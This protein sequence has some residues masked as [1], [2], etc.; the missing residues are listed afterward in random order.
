M[1]SRLGSAK[2]LL[3][4]ALKESSRSNQSAASLKAALFAVSRNGLSGVF[5]LNGESR[6]ESQKCHTIAAEFDEQYFAQPEGSEQSLSNF[7]KARSVSALAFALAGEHDEAIY[8]A[9]TSL[10]DSDELEQLVLGSLRGSA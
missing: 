2:P 8:E 7:S 4:Q 5:L 1:T 9:M 6:Y 10:N 3:E